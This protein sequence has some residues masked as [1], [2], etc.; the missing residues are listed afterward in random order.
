MKEQGISGRVI[1][2]CRI[3]QGGGSY[4]EVMLIEKG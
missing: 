4:D 1:L 3:F 2:K